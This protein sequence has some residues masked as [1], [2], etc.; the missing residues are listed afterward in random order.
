MIEHLKHDIL[1][2]FIPRTSDFLYHFVEPGPTIDQ[3]VA[4]DEMQNLIS[5]ELHVGALFLLL[6]GMLRHATYSCGSP[7][8]RT[9]A[10]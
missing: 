3:L 9:M 8:P 1:G 10:V 4:D 5:R 2:V 7:V 6:Q